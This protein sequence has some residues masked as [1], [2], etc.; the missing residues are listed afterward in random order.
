M[1][2]HTNHRATCPRCE[3]ESVD[4]TWLY[5]SHPSKCKKC[6]LKWEATI[7][8]R[9]FLAYWIL[10][11][12]L[13]LS[14]D[15]AG[16]LDWLKGDIADYVIFGHLASLIIIPLILWFTTKRYKVWGGSD[17]VRFA[18]NYGSIFAFT[19]TGIIVCSLT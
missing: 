12:G 16:M 13:I 11:L 1:Y 10:I 7:A 9:V 17:R 2:V 4:S 8:S 3:S 6:K 18:I 15:D 14:M 19:F 5:S